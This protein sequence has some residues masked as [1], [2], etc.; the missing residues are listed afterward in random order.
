VAVDVLSLTD[1]V[2]CR[3]LE[4]PNGDLQ[5]R[6]V[7]DDQ[8]VASHSVNPKRADPLD[9]STLSMAEPSMVTI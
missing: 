9:S 6:A 8:P 3:A 2:I 5:M 4:M 1:S 7:P